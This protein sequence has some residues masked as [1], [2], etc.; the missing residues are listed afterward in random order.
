MRTHEGQERQGRGAGD[1]PRGRLLHSY[2]LTLVHLQIDLLCQTVPR[3]PV[4]VPPHHGTWLQVEVPLQGSTKLEQSPSVV[5]VLERMPKLI[6]TAL[7]TS[8]TLWTK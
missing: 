3:R 5:G 6:N 8:L 4:H 2:A 1:S 7:D